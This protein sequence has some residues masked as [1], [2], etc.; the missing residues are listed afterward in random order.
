MPKQRGKSIGKTMSKRHRKGQTG[1]LGISNPGVKRLARRAGVKRIRRGVYDVIKP[2]AQEFLMALMA[3]TMLFTN[4]CRRKTISTADVV[5]AYRQT[6]GNR[7][8]GIPEKDKKMRF[9]PLKKK[10]RE[11]RAAAAAAQEDDAEVEEDA[12]A[13]E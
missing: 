2:K 7:F 1:R 8:V 13:E 10:D 3:N 9:T 4:S 6:T 11:A 12:E 5:E